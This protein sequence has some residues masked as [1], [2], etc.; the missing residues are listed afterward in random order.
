MAY[1]FSLLSRGEAVLAYANIEALDK[2]MTAAM[3]PELQDCLHATARRHLEGLTGASDDTKLAFNA[4]VKDMESSIAKKVQS[5]VPSMHWSINSGWILVEAM[6]AV[7]K[8]HAL[9]ILAVAPFISV[10]LD[11]ASAHGASYLS[12]HAYYLDKN[13]NQVPL[14]LKLAHVTVAP[15][16]PNLLELLL[17]TLEDVAGLKPADLKNKV[18]VCKGAWP[19]YY[20]VLG[21]TLCLAIFCAWPYYV[22]IMSIVI[23]R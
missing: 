10:S 11:E 12:V 5:L 1:L 22:I 23:D 16:A 7:A 2:H 19:Y 21:H 20:Y 8:A 17:E 3:V 15:N 13:W 14:F 18:C 9:E 4:M 6:A